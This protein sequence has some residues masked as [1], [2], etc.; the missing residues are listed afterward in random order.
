MLALSA[1]PMLAGLFGGWEFVLLL[2]LVL[3]LVYSRYGSTPAR[4]DDSASHEG[5]PPERSRRNEFIVWLAQGLDVGRIPV[6]PGTFGSLVGLLWVAL[7]LVS[8]SLPLYL[9]G[10]AAGLMLSVWCCGRAEQILGRSDPGSVVLDEIAALPVC[11]LPWIIRAS[12]RDGVPELDVFILH[13]G[14]WKTA[15]LFGLFRLFDV[16][17]PWPIR[18]SQALPGGWG[19]TIDDFLAATYVALLS[20]LWIG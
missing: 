6:A 16:L 18:Q 10:T 9:G 14:W 7:L 12:N 4:E 19:V 17:K 3:L 2:T 5:K 20:L 13:G 8:G 1:S 15:I 11:F